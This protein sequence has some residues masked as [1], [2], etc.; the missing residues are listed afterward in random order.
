MPDNDF[1]KNI[2]C[3]IMSYQRQGYGRIWCNEA[4]AFFDPKLGCLGAAA[5]K[6]YITQQETLSSDLSNL[7]GNFLS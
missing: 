2:M 1:E 7:F 5:L 4:C 3:P 6:S